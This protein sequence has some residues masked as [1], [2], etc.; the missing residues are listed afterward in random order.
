MNRIDRLLGMVTLLQSKKYVQAEKIAEKYHISVRT[1]YRDIKTLCEQGIP[2]SFEPHKGYFIVQG[3][4]LPPV[5]FTSDEANALL[6]MENLVR[7]FADKS[8]KKHYS[9]ALGKIKSVLHPAQKE[10]LEALNQNIKHQVPERFQHDFEYLSGLQNAISS[11]TVIEISYRNNKEE[12]SDR[13][14]EPIGLIYYAFNW[15][16]V[17]WCRKRSDY[18]DFRVSRILELKQTSL[19]FQ[20]NNHIELHE[21]MKQLPV[22]W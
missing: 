9:N 10:K 5:S 8:I 1:V 15:H 12:T 20:K 22:P 2:V 21:Y 6:L 13:R 4:F 16:L 3:Y 18:R 19:P 14:V 7:S 17:A 11:K